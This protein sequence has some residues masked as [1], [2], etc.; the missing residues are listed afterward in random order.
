MFGQMKLPEFQAWKR[1]EVVLEQ[2]KLERHLELDRRKTRIQG[3]LEMKWWFQVTR[4]CGNRSRS[5]ELKEICPCEQAIA[6]RGEVIEGSSLTARSRVDDGVEGKVRKVEETRMKKDTPV[7][8]YLVDELQRSNK[9]RRRQRCTHKVSGDEEEPPSV[10]NGRSSSMDICCQ[11]RLEEEGV[12]WVFCCKKRLWWRATRSPW[13]LEELR[14]SPNGEI[15]PL[16]PMKTL[17]GI[18]S[19]WL[20]HQAY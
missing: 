11:R 4:S 16:K 10:V 17:I 19:A 13:M 1:V 2:K 5:K 8:R 7:G 9:R 14:R 6:V 18:T 20:H 3:K 12:G 15:H